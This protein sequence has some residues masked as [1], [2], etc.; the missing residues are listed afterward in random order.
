[1]SLLL[2][3]LE[4]D[5]EGGFQAIGRGFDSEWDLLDSES[6]G[7]DEDVWDRDKERR[8]TCAEDKVNHEPKEDG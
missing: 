3:N 5:V 1:M 7:E 4:L 8:M 2:L 6:L